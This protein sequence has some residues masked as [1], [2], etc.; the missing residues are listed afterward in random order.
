MTVRRAPLLA[1]T[2]ALLSV[3]AW[4]QAPIIA[5]TSLPVGGGVFTVN[6]AIALQQ[7]TTQFP[8]SPIVWS[9][10]NGNLPP[11]LS[12][13]GNSGPITGTP[14]LAGAFTFTVSATDVSSNLTGSQQYTLFVS[15]G[16]PL[17]LTPLTHPSG[18]IGGF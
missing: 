7:L 17:T 8:N 12:L 1:T 16:S 2:L 4:G 5:P 13:G 9:V 14:T 6:K 15:T 11:G 10:S 18:A 3:S